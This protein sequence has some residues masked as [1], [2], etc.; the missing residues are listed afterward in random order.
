MK[1]SINSTRRR[2]LKAVASLPLAGSGV[3]L[4]S[5]PLQVQAQASSCSPKSLVCLF[6]AGGADSFNTF[7]PG[8]PDAYADYRAARN[9][10]AV[11]EADLIEVTDAAQGTFG[12]NS[13]TSSLSR[14]YTE[15]RLG[16]VSNT[17]P[18]IRP[19]T[20]NDYQNLVSIPQSLFAHNT[21]QKLWQTGAGF[22]GGSNAFGWGGAI[23]DYAASCNVNQNL[24]S[25]IS[26]AGTNDWQTSRSAN[27]ISLNAS[28]TVD[29]MLGLSNESFW[30]PGDRLEKLDTA[31][32]ALSQQGMNST[33]SMHRELSGAFERANSATDA[34]HLALLSH[35]LPQMQY[36]T[37]NGFAAQLHL[38]ARL[39]AAR[40]DLGM[41]QQVFFVRMGGWD[42]HSNQN[43]RLPALL[44]AFNEGID[45]FTNTL[46]DISAM[47][48]VTAFTASDFGRTLTSNGNGTDHG[49][50]G[51]NFV[52]GGAVKGGQIFG[53]MPSYASAGNPD[54]ASE[55]DSAFAGRIIPQISVTQY[56]ATIARW[57]G[58]PESELLTLFPDLV[59]FGVKDI[60]F[61]NT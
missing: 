35:T 29:R 54:D 28:S 42:T 56:G 18:L 60:G 37:Q 6:L 15:G 34:L 47:N 4:L 55:S 33:S 36:N 13:L 45:A 11:A 25:A 26:L 51:H 9:E 16:V 57:M 39:I 43:Q 23:A 49:W 52:F 59:N 21:Q 27:Y 20:K 22:V 12:F 10:L 41:Q 58:V 48:T 5:A 53:D 24:P 3:S 19:T 50:G 38:V 2:L 8:N 1:N 40:D 31:F 46:D 61:M 14:L 7:V 17:G 44:S 30:I 32:R